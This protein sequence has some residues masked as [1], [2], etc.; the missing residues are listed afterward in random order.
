MRFYKK[1]ACLPVNYIN[2]GVDHSRFSSILAVK[3]LVR[4]EHNHHHAHRAI[5]CFKQDNLGNYMEK[6]FRHFCAQQETKQYAPYQW[7]KTWPGLVI[8]QWSYIRYNNGGEV[9]S[10]VS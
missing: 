1:F 4:E 7:A 2:L 6:M 3:N 8:P 5:V 10:D 9:R